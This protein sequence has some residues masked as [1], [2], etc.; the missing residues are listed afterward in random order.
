MF[1]SPS[2]GFVFLTFLCSSSAVCIS[3]LAKLEQGGVGSCFLLVSLSFDLAE[4]S[5]MRAEPTQYC[6]PWMLGHSPSM[7]LAR[8]V[9]S[10]LRERNLLL[11]L[12][13]LILPLN[14]KN[15]T[16]SIKVN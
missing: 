6:T 10:N 4:H 7:K 8:N 1:F 12:K 15:K 2:K 11:D 5:E 9:W 13:E 14:N 16:N 3:S